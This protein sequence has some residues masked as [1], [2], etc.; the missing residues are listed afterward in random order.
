MYNMNNYELDYVD[1]NRDSQ[2]LLYQNH[3]Y[4][5]GKTETVLYFFLFP[6]KLFFIIHLS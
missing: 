4:T 3:L 1:G 6:Q 2:L 5:D